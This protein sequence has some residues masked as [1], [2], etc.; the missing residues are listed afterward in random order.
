MIKSRGLC[1]HG[2]AHWTLTSRGVHTSLQD[3]LLNSVKSLILVGPCL[4]TG[5]CS[6]RGWGWG[7]RGK[8]RMSRRHELH[9][10]R[11]ALLMGQKHG[12][13]VRSRHPQCP[14]SPSNSLRG[15]GFYEAYYPLLH[16]VPQLVTLF[17]KIITEL[18]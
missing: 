13:R 18:V 9:E 10:L 16:D 11:T 2:G 5:R 8:R 15:K 12:A 7:S 3:P 4:A 17:P 1:I 6:Y 14:V